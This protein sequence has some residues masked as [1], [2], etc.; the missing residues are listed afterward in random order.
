[1]TIFLVNREILESF[2]R[3]DDPTLRDV[4][5]FYIKDVERFVATGWF[6]SKTRIRT[7][8]IDDFELQM[9][10]IQETF[11]RAFSDGARLAYDGIRPYRTF[12]LRIA[13]NVIIDYLRKRPRDAL[14]HACV[15]F[16]DSYNL[17]QVERLELVTADTT[18]REEYLD[19]QRQI[20]ATRELIAT[21]DEVRRK[22]VELRF[23][24]ELSLLEVARRLG[25]SRGKARF[26][27]NDLGRRL[28]KHF[29]TEK[30][31]TVFK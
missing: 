9:E 25:I 29:K 13:R 14:S 2:R 7:G 8:R 18:Q 20:S 15:D 11:L 24:Q 26:L 17:D 5:I 19:W 21:F 12:L 3:G 6:D 10:L 4:Y 30:L 28:K 23:R 22:F 31:K 1:M 16:D 27:E